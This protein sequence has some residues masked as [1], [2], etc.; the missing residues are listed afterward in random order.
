MGEAIMWYAAY[1]IK[2]AAAGGRPPVAA[3]AAAG[4][5]RPKVNIPADV[6]ARAQEGQRLVA[7]KRAPA[8]PQ[9]AMNPAVRNA[10]MF[11]G[12]GAG[13]LGL[14]YLLGGPLSKALMPDGSHSRPGQAPEAND[15]AAR[16]NKEM[17]EKQRLA[18]STPANQ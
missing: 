2:S 3:A 9:S 6:K 8:K 5:M 16:I 4:G 12:I 13:G 15:P 14:G 17:E 1:L 7:M 10:L 18:Q 11:G